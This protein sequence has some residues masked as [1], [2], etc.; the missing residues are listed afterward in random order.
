MF[1]GWTSDLGVDLVAI[2]AKIKDEL[3]LLDLVTTE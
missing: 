1:D 3:F 2:L